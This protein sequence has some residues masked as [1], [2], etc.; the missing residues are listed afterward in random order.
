MISEKEKLKNGLMESLYE[1]FSEILEGTPDFDQA[2][3]TLISLFSS[4]ADSRA[5]STHD[6]FSIHITID[7]NEFSF[8]ELYKGDG[9]SYLFNL[10]P[11]DGQISLEKL[12][13]WA[14]FLAS[15]IEANR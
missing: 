2:R 10:S 7:S 12:I 14:S 1:S 9:N 5:V 8:V 6:S 15:Y 11:P 3:D 13:N 4:I